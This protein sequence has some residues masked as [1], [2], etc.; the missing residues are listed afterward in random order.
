MAKR[1]TAL[2]II[3]ILFLF[4]FS[5]AGDKGSCPCCT[6]ENGRM[7][8]TLEEDRVIKDYLNNNIISPNFGLSTDYFNPC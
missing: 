2:L 8:I 4:Y 3:V 5:F 1:Y 6:A 7:E